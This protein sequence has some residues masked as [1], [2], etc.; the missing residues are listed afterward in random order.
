MMTLFQIAKSKSPLST[1]RFL[2]WHENKIGITG[3]HVITEMGYKLMKIS[4]RMM[5]FGLGRCSWCGRD[6]GF[7]MSVSA[8]GC[9][10]MTQSRCEDFEGE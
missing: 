3:R 6:M 8:K 1:K 5:R 7:A 2:F 10:R 9:R 4:R